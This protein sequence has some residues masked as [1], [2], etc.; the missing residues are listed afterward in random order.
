MPVGRPSQ[1]VPLV[2][3]WQVDRRRAVAHIAKHLQ[4]NDGNVLA[5][6]KLLRVSRRTLTR[7]IREEPVLRSIQLKSRDN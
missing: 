6:A 3:C 1:N 4:A 5:T 2:T 7:W